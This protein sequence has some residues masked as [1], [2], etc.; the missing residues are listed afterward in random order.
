MEG[1]TDNEKR[2]R[3]I[4]LM[5]ILKQNLVDFIDSLIQSARDSSNLVMMRTYLV[6]HMNEREVMSKG[7]ELIG[8]Y[9]QRI[10]KRD[11][12][13]LER[14]TD[15]QELAAIFSCLADLWNDPQFDNDDKNNVWEWLK[16]LA[17]IVNRYSALQIRAPGFP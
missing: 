2:E 15:F 12:F 10:S 1:L 13:F 6:G 4:K 14:A 9:E 17:G 11:P 8:P 5:K 3:G 16:T 7:V